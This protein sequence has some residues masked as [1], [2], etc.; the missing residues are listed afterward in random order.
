LS[1]SRKKAFLKYVGKRKWRR[2]KRVGNSK[3]KNFLIY[4]GDRKWKK[5]KDSKRHIML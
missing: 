3:E 1:L 2:I 4:L 5:V